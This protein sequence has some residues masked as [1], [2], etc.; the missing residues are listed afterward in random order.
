[1]SDSKDIGALWRKEKDGK[2]YMT[3][4]ITIGDTAHEIVVFK[5]GFKEKPNQSDWRI[6]K[7]KPREEVAAEVATIRVDEEPESQIPF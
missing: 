1:M 4:T 6:Y 3:G 7:S 2:E 5:N